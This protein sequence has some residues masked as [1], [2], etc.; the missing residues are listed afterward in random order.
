MKLKPGVSISHKAKKYKGEIPD[1]IVKE[2]EKN[3]GDEKKF[4]EWKKKFS[5][6]P[7]RDDPKTEDV[8]PVKDDPAK[9]S[10]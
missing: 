4:K 8:E 5:Y 2:F 10:G 3:I 7:K 6:D 9:S 1:E